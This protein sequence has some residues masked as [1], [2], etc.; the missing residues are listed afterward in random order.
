MH[1]RVIRRVFLLGLTLGA[2]LYW[3]LPETVFSHASF[4]ETAQSGKAGQQ[5][6]LKVPQSEGFA[7]EE[8]QEQSRP[9]EEKK[10][11]PDAPKP[12]AEPERKG[13]PPKKFVPSEKIPADQAVDFPAD[14]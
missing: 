14:I 2:S 12:K 5:L 8:K 6:S 4:G 9:G 1:Y 7:A 10:P 11:L 13:T 3:G